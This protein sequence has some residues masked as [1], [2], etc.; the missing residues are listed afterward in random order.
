[1]HSRLKRR[2][3]VNKEES[4]LM[5]YMYLK[6]LKEPLP[7]DDTDTWLTTD[8]EKMHNKRINLDISKDEEVM[9]AN[10]EEALNVLK[11][12]Q[13]NPINPAHYNDYKHQPIEVMKEWCDGLHGIKAIY[14]GNIIKYIARWHKKN[15]LED[16]KKAARY[17]EWLIEDVERRGY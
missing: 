7:M 13:F 4:N 10:L 2:I 6:S 12:N 3:R 17:L 5:D 15:G 14:T 9:R 8:D 1:M 11:N 16:L